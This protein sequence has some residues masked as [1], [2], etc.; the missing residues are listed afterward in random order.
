MACAPWSMPASRAGAKL[1][2]CDTGGDLSKEEAEIRLRELAAS[3][4][5]V[6]RSV[7]RALGEVRSGDIT[8]AGIDRALVM[9]AGDEDSA[10]RSLAPSTRMCDE[11]RIG[12]PSWR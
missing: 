10:T 6:R 4:V 9:L 12:R 8:G 5:E 2:F 7:A 3:S 1:V 11:R